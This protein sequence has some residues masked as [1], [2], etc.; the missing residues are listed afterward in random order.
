MRM[1]PRVLAAFIAIASLKGDQ[2]KLTEDQR[3]ELLRGLLSEY[4]TVR[5]PLPRSKK[6]LEF[7]ADG[8]YDKQQWLSVAKQL[9]PA[10]RIG[11][12]VQITHITIE[13]DS[14]LFEINHGLKSQG[15]WKD[16]LQIG[17]NGGM[18]PVS[19][20]DANAPGGTNVLLKFPDAIGELSSADVK[21]I[22]A[23]VLEFEKHSATDNYVDDL[24]PAVKVAIAEKKP[25]EGMDRDQV[26]LAMGRPLHK[27][28]ENRDG[29]DYE[30]WIYGQ[31]P[32]RVTFVTFIGPK[33][34][35]V[36]DTYAGLG[37][38]VADTPKQP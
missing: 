15:S 30:D 38:S 5:A 2:K 29:V 12:L 36:K 18:A 9:G 25:I 11:D 20:G 17:V 6:P 10:A 37:G 16:H 27:S 22:L 32:G 7:N 24:P 8:T 14:I 26:L 13:K 3:I 34:V 28:R 1:Y 21:K 31:P 35:K 19:R 33:V 4:A 23:P